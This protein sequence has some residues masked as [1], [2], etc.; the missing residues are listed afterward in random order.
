MDDLSYWRLT[1]FFA[2]NLIIDP[3]ILLILKVSLR[4]QKSVVR[5]SV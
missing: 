3:F 4:N 1:V 2:E 5:I